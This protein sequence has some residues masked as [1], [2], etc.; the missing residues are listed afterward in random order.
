M[1]VG[2]GFFGPV[3]KGNEEDR[4]KGPFRTYTRT[5][6]IRCPDCGSRVRVDERVSMCWCPNCSYHKHFK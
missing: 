2:S 1:K 3:E 6:E 4:Q 5:S